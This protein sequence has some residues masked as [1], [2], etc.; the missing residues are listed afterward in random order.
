[1]ANPPLISVI[2]PCYNAKQFLARCLNSVFAEDG[3]TFEVIVVNDGSTDGTS[4]FVRNAFGKRENLKLITNKENVGSSQSKNIGVKNSQGA[5][6]FFLDGDTKVK[7]G[8]S[9]TIPQFFENHKKAGLAQAKLLRMETDCF[10]YGGDLISSF[11]FLVERAKGARDQGQFDQPKP[12]FSLKTAGAIMKKAVFEDIHGFDPDYRIFWEDTDIAWRTWL[13]GS[14]VLF[15]PDITVWHAFN[16]PEKTSR[17]Y[18][19]R[20][21]SYQISYF[22]CRNMV[23]SLIKNLELKRLIFVLPINISCWLILAILFLLRLNFKKSGKILKGIGW[24]LIFLPKTLGKRKQIQMTRAISDQK[25]FSLV[26][27]KQSFDYYLHKAAAY[28]KNKPFY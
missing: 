3:K 26:G 27:T 25:L 9:K 24:N 21:K 15:C 5:Y 8:W 11:G 18:Q 28:I 23:S 14:E 7:P 1:M 16:T 19:E 17:Y 13:R 22:G 6:L 20:E 10:D 4:D 12:I 2:I